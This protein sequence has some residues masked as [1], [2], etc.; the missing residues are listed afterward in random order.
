MVLSPKELLTIVSPFFF[1]VRELFPP[2]PAHA[3]L[4][5]FLA[6]TPFRWSCFSCVPFARHFFC[7]TSSSSE[8]P[9]LPLDRCFF[10][11]RDCFYFPFPFHTPAIV[12]CLFPTS[13]F[14]LVLHRSQSVFSFNLALYFPFSEKFFLQSLTE[15]SFLSFRIGDV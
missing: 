12:L 4:F 13:P 2:P 6:L 9:C 7:F 8:L 10:L 3:N 15:P 14:S 11:W 1:V 5:C